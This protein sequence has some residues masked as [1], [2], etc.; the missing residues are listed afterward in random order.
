MPIVMAGNRMWKDIVK[1]NWMRARSRADRP[2][3]RVPSLCLG[4]ENLACLLGAHAWVMSFL[5]ASVVCVQT[6][7]PACAGRT[8]LK[9]AVS[10]DIVART[11]IPPSRLRPGPRLKLTVTLKFDIGRFVA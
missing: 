9:L 6:W 10:V 1:A 11:F 2:N 5:Y 4:A 8:V 3:M 7:V